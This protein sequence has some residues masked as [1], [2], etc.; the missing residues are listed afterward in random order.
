[1]LF[2][3]FEFTLGAFVG[4]CVF[5]HALVYHQQHGQNAVLEL[6]RATATPTAAGK[7]GVICLSV[8][9]SGRPSINT[10]FFLYI[11]DS[12]TSVSN[13]VT[14]PCWCGADITMCS[15]RV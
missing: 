9:L 1:M 10:D 15:K 5:V 11:H 12:F 14:K 3:P 2:V 7:A 13:S 8:F 4:V 6:S